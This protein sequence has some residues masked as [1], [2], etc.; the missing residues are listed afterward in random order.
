[1]FAKR[2]TWIV[3]LVLLAVAGT[4]AFGY[5]QHKRYKHW[6]AHDPGMVYR[7]AWLEA[8]VF[9][10]QIEKYQIRAVLNLC[11][12]G[13]LGEQRCIDQRK[14]VEGA[15]ARLIALPMPNTIDASD[16]EVAKFVE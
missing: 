2:R 16:P 4:S 10:E 5:R 9:A 7:C 15:G 8:D 11:N 1:M 12:P 14:A 6:A 13:E 3:G